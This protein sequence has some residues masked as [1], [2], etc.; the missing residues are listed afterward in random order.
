MPAPATQHC[1]LPAGVRPA[2]LERNIN[3]NSSSNSQSNIIRTIPVPDA[4][5]TS[6][7]TSHCTSAPPDPGAGEA[8]RHTPRGCQPSWTPP[9]PLLQ[10]GGGCRP[11]LCLG[12]CH[13]LLQHLLLALIQPHQLNRAQLTSSSSHR[14]GHRPMS[15]HGC[16]AAAP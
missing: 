6:H 7:C 5:C 13:L 10:P 4:G 8:H 9:G 12:S 2:E 1:Q 11:H 16:W 15:R 3:V 14:P